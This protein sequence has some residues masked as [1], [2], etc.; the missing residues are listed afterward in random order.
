MWYK[1]AGVSVC[2]GRCYKNVIELGVIM[3]V[4]DIQRMFLTNTIPTT[5]SAAMMTGAG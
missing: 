5:K 4:I 1:R 3:C 2:S